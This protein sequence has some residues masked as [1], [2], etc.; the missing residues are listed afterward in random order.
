MT[1]TGRVTECSELVT[2][3]IT[4]SSVAETQSVG[5]DG[6]DDEF[7]SA[8]ANPVLVYSAEYRSSI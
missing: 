6:D 5:S 2:K 7:A 4:Q 3:V 1:A 8:A